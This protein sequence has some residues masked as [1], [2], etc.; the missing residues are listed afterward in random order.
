M[1][2]ILN[3]YSGLIAIIALLITI[4]IGIVVNLITPKIQSWIDKRSLNNVCKRISVI[5]L[6]FQEV[7]KQLSEPTYALAKLLHGLLIALL[8]LFLLMQISFFLIVIVIYYVQLVGKE[9]LKLF[10]NII[11]PRNI[12][13]SIIGFILGIIVSYYCTRGSIEFVKKLRRITSYSDWKKDK[14]NELEQLNKLLLEKYSKQ[15]EGIDER[16][17]VKSEKNISKY[18]VIKKKKK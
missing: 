16:L 11:E 6:D 3:Q 9:E 7:D 10:V 1:N 13:G 12:I 17:I 5:N 15:K 14:E 18:H 2:E 4:P 8:G